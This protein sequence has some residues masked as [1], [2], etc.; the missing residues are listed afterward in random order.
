M[1]HLM[2]AVNFLLTHISLL[3]MAAISQMAISNAFSWMQVVYFDSNVIEVF[4]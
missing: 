4:M 1:V 3:K 2:F